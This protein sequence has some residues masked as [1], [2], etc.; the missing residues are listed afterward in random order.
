MKVIDADWEMRNLGCKTVEIVVGK[1]DAKKQSDEICSELAQAIKD[2]EARYVV[3]KVDTRYSAISLRLQHEGYDLI[4]VQAT[5]RQTRE[6]AEAA[7]ERFAPFAEGVNY[8]EAQ[9]EDV[10]MVI[11]EVRKGI[12]KTDRIALDPHF[13]V[14]IANLRYANWIQ[15]EVARKTP[16]Y[17]ATYQDMPLGFML[18]RE[19][20]RGRF[21]GLL[22]GLFTDEAVQGYGSLL[23]YASARELVD[24]GM[25]I[26]EGGMSMNNPKVVQLHQAYGQIIMRLT[27]VFIR[28]L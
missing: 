3:V 1:E 22:L 21:H 9:P 23:D 6:A 10:A 8:Y 2:H 19:Q 11:R 5:S 16:L 7:L 14:E 15:D 17:I 12:F 13:G 18:N 24:H 27:N 25:R 20:Q 4:E 26:L 28:H